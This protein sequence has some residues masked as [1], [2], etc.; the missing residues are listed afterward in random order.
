[1]PTRDL[2]FADLEAHTLNAAFQARRQGFLHT[3]EALE[4]LLCE[5]C[6]ERDM[7]LVRTCRDCNNVLA[8]SLRKSGPERKP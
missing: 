7:R 8:T 2:T 3:A 5:F 1:M 4:A 6:K